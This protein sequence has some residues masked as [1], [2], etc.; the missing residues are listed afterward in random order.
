MKRAAVEKYLAKIVSHIEE[1]TQEF[2]EDWIE[3]PDGMMAFAERN[4]ANAALAQDGDELEMRPG[5]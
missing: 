2:G 4:A 5:R 1:K 3:S